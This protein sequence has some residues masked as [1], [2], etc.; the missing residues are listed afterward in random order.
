MPPTLASPNTLTRADAGAAWQLAQEAQAAA[1]Q[2]ESRDMAVG[3]L[4]MAVACV[5]TYLNVFAQL[6]LDQNQSWPHRAAVEQDLRSK[7]PLGRKL[8]DWPPLF[9]D[10]AADFAS[11][12]GQDFKAL[13]GVRNRLMHFLAQTHDVARENVII[14]GLIDISDYSALSG[15]FA[16]RAVA[17]AEAF[18]GYLLQLQGLGE[19]HVRHALHHW[20]GKVPSSG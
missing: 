16:M 17:T 9:F 19:E 11:G 5:E 8:E 2:H 10:R 7:K 6:W 13:L 14:H 15:A 18:V 1:S 12:P 3:A 4:T 20:L